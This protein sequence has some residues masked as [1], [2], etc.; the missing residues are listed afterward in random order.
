MEIKMSGTDKAEC[1]VSDIFFVF[2]SSFCNGVIILFFGSFF[3]Q[4]YCVFV[5]ERICC[6]VSEDHGTHAVTVPQQLQ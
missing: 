6:G 4:I 2:T 5:T 1:L 3:F